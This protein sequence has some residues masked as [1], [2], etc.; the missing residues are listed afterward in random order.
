[1]TDRIADKIFEHEKLRKIRQG[2]HEAIED[3]ITRYYDEI[4]RFCVYQLH[5]TDKAYDLDFTVDRLTPC[6]FAIS[7][8]FKSL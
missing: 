3:I 8:S 4:L 6:I 2:Y 5:D 7:V 1:M